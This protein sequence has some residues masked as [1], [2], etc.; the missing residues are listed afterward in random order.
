M[1]WAFGSTKMAG[2]WAEHHNLVATVSFRA[3]AS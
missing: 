1:I 3:T 2:S